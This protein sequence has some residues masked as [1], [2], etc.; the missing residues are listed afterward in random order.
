MNYMR[1]RGSLE[2]VTRAL[3]PQLA[4]AGP[5]LESGGFLG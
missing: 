2:I 1:A 4:P 5:W 3:A